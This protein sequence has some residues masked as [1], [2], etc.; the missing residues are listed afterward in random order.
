[1][2]SGVST[3]LYT[4]DIM[5]K[6]RFWREELHQINTEILFS[7]RTSQYG[8][9]GSIDAPT[10]TPVI[11][12]YEGYGQRLLLLRFACMQKLSFLAN[13]LQECSIGERR[14][15]GGSLVQQIARMESRMDEKAESLIRDEK[16]RRFK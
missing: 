1:M 7:V 13:N 15:V 11:R 2:T 12:T 3:Q 6:E 5:N 10:G 16:C 8:N 14:R 4:R 9:N